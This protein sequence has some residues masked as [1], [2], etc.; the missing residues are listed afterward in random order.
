MARCRGT[1]GGRGGRGGRRAGGAPRGCRRR[2]AGGGARAAAGGRRCRRGC[3]RPRSRLGSPRA[4]F[5]VGGGASAR[6]LGGGGGGD[7][8]GARPRVALGGRL[9]AGRGG[10]HAW[11]GSTRRRARPWGGN[12]WVCASAG[13]VCRSLIVPFSWACA[14]RPQG[15]ASLP[16]CFVRCSS[17]AQ[18]HAVFSLHRT[19]AWPKSIIYRPQSSATRRGGKQEKRVP[20]GGARH[21]LHGGC[22][23]HARCAISPQCRR[24]DPPQRPHVDATVATVAQTPAATARLPTPPPTAHRR[25]ATTAS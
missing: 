13:G 25:A 6:A 24:L 11:G 16:R 20:D 10:A 8:A 3:R 22:V 12:A 18:C 1:S 4:A 14:F 7:A 2:G 19:V 5:A 9:D 17:R 15:C 23:S 21:G